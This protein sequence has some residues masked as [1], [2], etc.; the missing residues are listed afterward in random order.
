MYMCKVGMSLEGVELPN[1]VRDV[2]L[3]TITSFGLD[4]GAVDLLVDRDG[5]V[6]VS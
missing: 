6:V 1:Q 3:H 5:N 2:A 4:F